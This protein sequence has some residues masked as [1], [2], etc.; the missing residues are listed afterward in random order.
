[1][2]L[3]KGG[4]PIENTILFGKYQFVHTLGQGRSGT[5]LLVYHLELDEYR[6][7]KQVPKSC[8]GYEQFKKEALLLTS[9]NHPG[10]PIVYDIEE[11]SKFSY[12]IEEYL[13]GD[14]LYDLVRNQGHLNQE[15][16]IRIGI[17]VCD[18]VHYL[19]SAGKTP[20]LYLDLQP[21]NLLFCHGHVKLLDFDHADHLYDANE[22]SLR[23]GT[24]GFCAPEQQTG[25][26][27]G[28][29]TDIYQIGALL[30]YLSAGH[31][32]KEGDMY[33]LDGMLG[34][35]IEICVREDKAQRYPTISELKQE[36]E[37]LYSQTGVFKD[38]HLSSLILALAGSRHGVGATHLALG[39]TKYLNQLGYKTL[40]EEQNHSGDVHAMALRCKSPLD[41]YGIYNIKQIAMK[42]WYGEAVCL[43]AVEYP[44]VI[45]DYGTEWKSVQEARD[46]STL[47]LVHGG[48]WWEQESGGLAIQEL[49]DC[50]E[51]ALLY[52][53]IIPDMRLDLPEG[54]DKRL[55]FQIPDFKNPWKFTQEVEGFFETLVKEC[56]QKKGFLP[57]QKKAKGQVKRGQSQKEKIARLGRTLWKCSERY[58]FHWTK[59]KE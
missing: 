50:P 42:P 30:Y 7:I 55:C 20:I 2:I 36:L 44:I 5:V 9:L 22:S 23:Y 58:L 21:K 1:M 10:I 59:R 14:T 52:N 57:M 56:L 39:L 37:T 16:V 49:K 8:A 6:A 15:A 24:P 26:A 27:L 38:S 48:K 29:Y 28:V 51:F 41:S 25:E 34:R 32:R 11:D 13:E 54:V 53:R 4:G 43:K 45:R 17:Q 19:H 40:Y 46:I 18:L 12:L 3:D 31:I 35:I 47:W 33:P